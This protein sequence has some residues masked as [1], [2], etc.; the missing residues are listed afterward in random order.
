M[1]WGIRPGQAAHERIRPGYE[2]FDQKK[3]MIFAGEWDARYPGLSDAEMNRNRDRNMARNV[4]GYR[5]EDW[6]YWQ[7]V[8]ANIAATG[9]TM[10]FSDW[11]ATSWTPLPR[12]G[13]DTREGEF[14]PHQGDNAAR[15]TA[16]L[17]KMALQLGAG[18]VGS[19]LLDRRYVY[20]RYWHPEDTA[21][22]P[23]CFDDEDGMPNVAIP[24]TL[25]DK[26]KVLPAGMQYALVLIFPMELA[27]IRK[28]PVFTHFA[29]TVQSYSLISYTTLA[30][31][32]FI[33]GLGYNAIPS[34]NDFAANIPLAIDAGLGELA[35][36]AKLAHPEYGTC[37][38]I[39]KVITD[40]PLVPDAPI[41]FG[42]RDFCKVCRHCAEKCPVKAVSTDD[43]MAEH[44]FGDY[45]NDH[46]RQWQLNHEK[47]RRQWVKLGTNCGVCLSQCLLNQK[48]TPAH[49]FE[50]WLIATAPRLNRTVY[51]SMLRRHQA[52]L[53][54][55]G[56]YWPA[57][58]L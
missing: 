27:G 58:S 26:T 57:E 12:A 10:H 50:K 14:A 48:N 29:T 31:A 20:S 42:V 55:E 8:S 34:A 56:E 54:R 41:Q 11:R 33:R 1:K 38:R 4:K 13:L 45:A 51:R 25:P 28:A 18:D 39:A 53:R 49:R 22:Y 16:L 19:C 46:V 5:A 35:R 6:A 15:N 47:C 52:A 37:C 21:S 3:H 43:D 2:R 7:A 23:I 9:F 44:P 32:E 40:L 30:L 36:N 24:T 17:K